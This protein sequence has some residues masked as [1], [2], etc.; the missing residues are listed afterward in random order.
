MRVYVLVMCCKGGNKGEYDDLAN[1]IKQTWGRDET[2]NVKVFY[3]WCEN[4]GTGDAKNFVLKKPEGYGMLLWKTLGFLQKYRNE[5]FDYIFR[6]NVGSYVHLQRL[7]DHLLTCPREKF[8]SGQPGK[9]QGI[10][11]VSGTGFIISRDL[12]MLAIDKIND[13]GHDHIDDIAF[14]K[15]FKEQNIKITPDWSRI[16]CEGERSEWETDKTYHW[17]L[18]NGDGQRWKDCENMKLL[19]NRFKNGK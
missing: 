19:Y 2:E 16:V 4:Y 6:V 10:P 14:G 3:L 11:F 12:A 17:K 1:T 5:D 15:F 8:Y 18:R 9:W 7:H 13:F